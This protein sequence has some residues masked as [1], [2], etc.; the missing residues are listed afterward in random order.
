MRLDA[1]S[2]EL[3]YPVFFSGDFR[4]VKIERKCLFLCYEKNDKAFCRY[5]GELQ[6]EGI[7]D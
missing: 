5:A 1:D 7:W 6:F 3:E 2:Q 4:E